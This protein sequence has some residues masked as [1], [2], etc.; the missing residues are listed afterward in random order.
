MFLLRGC[1]VEWWLGCCMVRVWSYTGV[2]YF[3]I[4]YFQSIPLESQLTGCCNSNS[5]VTPYGSTQVSLYPIFY[6]VLHLILHVVPNVV[7][8]VAPYVAPYIAPN[9]APILL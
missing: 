8:H 1:F 4:M 6:L 9:S 2:D 7:P 5:H 3:P